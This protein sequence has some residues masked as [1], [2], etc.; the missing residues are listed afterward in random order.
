MRPYEVHPDRQLAMIKAGQETLGSEWRIANSSP[1]GASGP[2]N[3]LRRAKMRVG[4]A[5]IEVGRRLAPAERP[6]RRVALDSRPD[7]GC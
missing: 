5:L 2:L 1:G 7:W 6:P 4:I 3:S